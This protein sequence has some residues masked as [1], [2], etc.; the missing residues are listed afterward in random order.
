MSPKQ[1]GDEENVPAQAE[2]LQYMVNL[3]KGNPYT[4]LAMRKKN[5]GI[6]S[7]VGG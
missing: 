4:K 3:H 5:G 7:L 6:V 2:L 1:L